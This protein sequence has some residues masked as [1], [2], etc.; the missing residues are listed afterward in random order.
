MT[1]ILITGSSGLIGSESAQF[2]HEKGFD[3]VGIDND[4][5][6]TFF[7]AGASTLPRRIELQSTLARYRHYNEDIRNVPFL[8]SLFREIGPSLAG[9]IHTAAQPS[10]DWASRDPLTDF[11]V[12]AQGTVNLLEMTRLYAPSSVFIH[13]STNKV[14]GDSPN[15]LP[16]V[17]L[18][19]RWEV[20]QSHHYAGVGIDTTMSIDQCLHSL[21]GVSKVAADIATQEY[22]RY[23]GLKTTTF[24]FGCLTGPGH[25]AAELHGFLA[26]LVRCTL[27]G[28]PYSIFGYKGK[29]VRDNLHSR[30][31]AEAFWQVFQKPGVG[32][33]YNLGGGVTS[34]C[35]VLEAIALTEKKTGRTLEVQVCDGART[36]DH[37]WWVSDNRAFETDY[38]EWSVKRGIETC[39]D[40]IL[41]HAG[42]KDTTVLEGV[43]LRSKTV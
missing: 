21:F 43:D 19:T 30:D 24:R 34:N 3:I 17:E 22:G 13:C 42:R 37:I 9:I 41:E 15:R 6:A 38:P 1:T 14:Y 29:Q 40:E 26:F 33:V 32:K 11:S 16:L 2:F 35:S 28:R 8:E 18:P 31:V 4:S 7:G 12:N 39:I 27:F 25:A 5:R 20:D 36:G 10:H 23:F